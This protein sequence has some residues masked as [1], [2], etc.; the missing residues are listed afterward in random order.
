MS[1][2]YVG[3]DYMEVNYEYVLALLLDLSPEE[4]KKIMGSCVHTLS[5]YSKVKVCVFVE[6]KRERE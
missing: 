2:Y 1:F 6:R 3:L 4:G 5:R